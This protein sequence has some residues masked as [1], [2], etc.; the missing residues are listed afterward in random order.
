MNKPLDLKVLDVGIKSTLRE[1]FVEARNDQDLNQLL[2]EIETLVAQGN[3]EIQH[4]ITNNSRTFQLEITNIEINRAKLSDAIHIN[5]N[6]IDLFATST[7]LGNSLTLQL[8][9]LDKEIS[10]INDAKMY[11]TN[12]KL[13]KNNINQAV[14]ALEH[15]NWEL[16]AKCMHTITTQIPHELV[17]G[18]YAS[19]LIPSAEI[20]EL[21]AV[22]IENITNQLTKVFEVKFTEAAA[23]RDVPELTQYF[24]LFPLIH[25]EEIG[26]NCYAKFMCQ[27]ISDTSRSLIQSVVNTSQVGIYSQ[28]VMQLLENISTMLSQHSPLIKRNY[29]Q[30]YP[31]AISYVITKIQHEIDSQIG[32]IT[33]TFYDTNRIDKVLQDIRLYDFPILN[34]NSQS[35][36]FQDHGDSAASK[37]FDDQELVTIVQAG[38]LVNEFAGIFNY[39]SLYCKFLAQRYFSSSKLQV[40]Q[41]IQESNFTKKTQAKYIPAFEAI[42]KFYF[43]RSLEKALIIEELPSLSPYLL[44]TSAKYP[45][46][47]AVSSIIEDFTLVLNTCLRAMVDSSHQTLLKLFVI[48][49]YK[50]ISNDLLNGY[51][52]KQLNENLPRYNSALNLT[53]PIKPSLISP[54]SLRSTT[55]TPETLGFFKGATNALGNVVGTSSALPVTPTTNNSRLVNFVIYLNTVATGQDYLTRII[56]NFTKQQSQYLQN[57]FPFEDDADIVKNILMN[58]LLNPFVTNTNKIIQEALISFYNQSIKNKIISIIADFINESDESNFVIYSSSHLNDTS[59]IYNFNTEWRNLIQPYKQIFHHDLIYNKLLRLVILN[60]A[61]LLEKRLISVIKKCNINELGALKLEKDISAFIGEVC[62]DNYE[63]REKFVRIT[64][65]VLLLGMDDDEYHESIHDD[66]GINWVLTP[67]ERT[68]FRK[69]R[70]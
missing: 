59:L 2:Q 3:D 51:I 5:D 57:C 50:V 15:K 47:P 26:L 62:D 10:R 45:E 67:Q 61:N 34:R 4:Y 37:I 29:S 38:D 35:Q 68:E 64:Q 55:P 36:N 53:N 48:S 28:I 56:N 27:I 9:S 8:K 69:F 13:L 30:T 16:A 49:S 32:L 41:L 63:L 17:H 43:R 44:T 21:P 70:I 33:D 20:P 22:I 7:D 31:R 1:K 46:L 12:T 11:V 60:V 24:Q 58:D 54:R 25:R 18:E 65:L 6:L 52:I 66:G 42:S 23:Q 14:Y 39:W 19:L 40:P